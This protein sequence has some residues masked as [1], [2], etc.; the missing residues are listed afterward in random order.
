MKEGFYP[1]YYAANV[2]KPRLSNKKTTTIAREFMLSFLGFDIIG[3]S[4]AFQ[5]R[6]GPVGYTP[7]NKYI[8]FDLSNF[9]YFYKDE[10]D[11]NYKDANNKK[12]HVLSTQTDYLS[13]IQDKN[14]VDTE[15]STRP[16]AKKYIKTYG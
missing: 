8:D 14:K 6:E 3:A 15:L 16:E 7:T 9:N 1:I 5:P 10:Y 11:M 2:S 12:A 13:K 4:L